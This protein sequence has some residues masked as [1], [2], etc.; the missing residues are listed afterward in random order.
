MVD[1]ARAVG[2]IPGSGAMPPLRAGLAAD[3]GGSGGRRDRPAGSDPIGQESPTVRGQS[4]IR[5]RHE[6]P[7]FDCGFDTNSRTI[8]ALSPSTT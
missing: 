5:M 3:A 6:G 2:Q 4:G 7:F 8:G 1:R